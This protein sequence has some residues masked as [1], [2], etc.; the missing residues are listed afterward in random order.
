MLSRKGSI[1]GFENAQVTCSKTPPFLWTI[2]SIHCTVVL[3]LP[4]DQLAHPKVSILQS[5]N[6]SD[7]CKT[8]WAVYIDCVKPLRSKCVI[9]GPQASCC[10]CLPAMRGIRPSSSLDCLMSTSRMKSSWDSTSSSVA[11]DSTTSSLQDGSLK[12]LALWMLAKLSPLPKRREMNP[13]LDKANKVLRNPV[14]LGT[15]L[16]YFKSESHALNFK[17]CL[18]L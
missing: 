1:L 18:P 7:S 9:K 10:V 11:E 16:R 12:L 17:C 8:F 2:M 14:S 15:W 4:C 13:C 6:E 3:Y 5:K